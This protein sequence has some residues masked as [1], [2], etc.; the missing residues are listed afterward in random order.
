[1]R[2]PRMSWRVT[3]HST[4]YWPWKWRSHHLPGSWRTC[5]VDS[6]GTAAAASTQPHT[7]V[8][9]RVSTH[10]QAQAAETPHMLQPPPPPPPP[11]PLPRKVCARVCGTCHRY[12]AVTATAR[13]CAHTPML[14]CTRSMLPPSHLSQA[15]QHS[16]VLHR[17]CRRHC[18]R[19]CCRRHHQ[20]ADVHADAAH[21]FVARTHRL[22]PP[23]PLPPR[24]MQRRHARAAGVALPEPAHV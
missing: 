10:M 23:P 7:H 4:F 9:H 18:C 15:P 21:T 12:H 22:S 13:A 17:H 19:H 16:R 24:C 1:M 11:P 3:V 6:V 5:H 14:S 8:N 20:R 2:S